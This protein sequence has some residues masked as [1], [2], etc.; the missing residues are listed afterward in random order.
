MLED[1]FENLLTFSDFFQRL[2]KI[3]KDFPQFPKISKNF[4]KCCYLHFSK[5]IWRLPMILEDFI[6][7]AGSSSWALC[8]QRLPTRLPKI[9]KDFPQFPKISKN[10]KKCCYLHFSK[11]IWRLPMILEDFIKNAGSSSWALCDIFRFFPEISED[12][13]RFLKKISKISETCW[14]V[15]FCTLQCFFLSFP[16]NFQTF[17]KGDMNPYFW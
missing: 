7:N 4:K 10:F 6:K 2:P 11:D 16:K 8:F 9:S 15:C 14:N 17:N 1:R 13:R 3:S 12:F 5:D